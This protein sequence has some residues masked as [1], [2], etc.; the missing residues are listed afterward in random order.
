MKL[1]QTE[2]EARLAEVRRSYLTSLLEKRQA[3]VTKWAA[4]CEQ[5]QEE[6]YQSLY[7]IIHSLA[8]SAETF[9]LSD[10]TRDARKVIDLFKQQA[11]R[12][13]LDMHF[14]PVITASIDQLVASMTSALLEIDQR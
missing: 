8:G 7:L 3:I 6:T 13:K 2:I 14:Q 5:W 10:I 9:G 1:S 4:L 11:G 12:G